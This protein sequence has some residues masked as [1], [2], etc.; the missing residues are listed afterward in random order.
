LH[1]IAEA[2]NGDN[3]ALVAY[4]QSGI[5]VLAQHLLASVELQSGLELPA[6]WDQEDLSSF[7]LDDLCSFNLNDFKN[8]ANICDSLVPENR[9]SGCAGRMEVE[10]TVPPMTFL[11]S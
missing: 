6:T 8:L 4:A 3:P 5:P 11:Q 1:F 9:T 2:E 7:N 10:H